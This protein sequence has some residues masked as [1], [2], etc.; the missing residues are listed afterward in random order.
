M[1]ERLIKE[2]PEYFDDKPIS[3]NEFSMHLQ[4]NICLPATKYK[5]KVFHDATAQM[6]EEHHL[7]DRIRRLTND[8]EKFH[9]YLWELQNN[10]PIDNYL[11]L[12][13]TFTL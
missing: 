8:G 7:K 2:E 10:S 9:P 5:N 6:T 13:V 4:N 12:F 11:K 1:L 3:R